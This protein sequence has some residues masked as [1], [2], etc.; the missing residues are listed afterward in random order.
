[1]TRMIRMA[2]LLADCPTH[3]CLPQRAGCAMLMSPNKDETDVYGCLKVLATPRG[4]L[5]VLQCIIWSA[6][7][8]K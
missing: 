2:R 3:I 6:F 5:C 8:L 7:L 1:M 4:W